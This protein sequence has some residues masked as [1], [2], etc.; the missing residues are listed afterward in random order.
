MAGTSNWE[1]TDLDLPLEENLLIRAQGIQTQ[2]PS[3]WGGTSTYESRC[4]LFLR[5]PIR[6]TEIDPFTQSGDTLEFIELYDGGLGNFS[7]DDYVLVLFDGADDAS[8]FALDLDGHSTDAD[9]YFLIGSA[10]VPGVDLVIPGGTLQN[11]AD[12][13][14][15]F[16]G[17][18]ADFPDDSPVTA[19]QLVD[20]VVYDRGQDDDP[21][22]AALLRPG[23]AQAN[24]ASNGINP[25][26]HSLQWF[27]GN[28]L[29][30]A[31]TPGAANSFAP[32]PGI[33]DLA[34]RSDRGVSDTDNLTS[35][36]LPVFTCTA[37]S[38]SYILLHSDRDGTIGRGSTDATG[39]WI[40]TTTIPLTDGVHQVSA[41]ADGSNPGPALEVTIVAGSIFQPDLLIGSSP[42]SAIGEE[43]Y[44]TLAGQVFSTVSRK[45]RP[46]GSVFV[47]QND[48]DIEDGFH[49]RSSPGNNLF[50]VTYTTTAEGN[51]TAK[52]VSGN[53][54]TG[55]IDPEGP[56]A[57]VNVSI[58]PNKKK[59][60]KKKRGRKKVLRKT[61]RLSITAK[62]LM[63]ET[64]TDRGQIR[65]QT[66]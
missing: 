39:T 2:N 4:L 36:N 20:A 60:L 14:A 18:E 61:L 27:N 52:I 37:R 22:L 41:T 50:R 9:G 17:A 16:E 59:L 33:P 45:A 31:P 51:V 66:K 44:D 26:G 42:A 24:E 43:I 21:G 46:V 62:S 40:A 63:Q 38:G 32:P 19:T 48:G 53:Y 64:E 55:P 54:S 56:P 34:S 35:D 58:R 29:A 57:M 47:L 1:L 15:L 23:Q 30:L 7:L 12:A 5:P 6:I 8:Y 65:V 10:S 11:G 3:N 13:V 49:A 28:W 25:G